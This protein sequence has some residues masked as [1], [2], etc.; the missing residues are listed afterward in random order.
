MVAALR[1]R[2]TSR[3]SSLISEF[4]SRRSPVRSKSIACCVPPPATFLPFRDCGDRD[5]R[6]ARAAT[7][8]DLAGRSV[9]ADLEVALRRVIRGVEDR[10]GD[11]LSHAAAPCRRACV[12]L[13]IS[14]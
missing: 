5:E 9:G 7:H 4:F 14:G 13:P 8:L 6:L 3:R 2:S 11:R 12:D 1:H 10:V